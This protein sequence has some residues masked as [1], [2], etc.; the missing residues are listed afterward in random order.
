MGEPLQTWEMILIGVL[1]IVMLFL[2]VPGLKRVFAESQ[3]A[4]KDWPGF[5]IPIGCVIAV[6]T[7]LI[8]I[9]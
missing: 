4:E 2:F 9:T 8:L 7:L 6:V 5:L 3:K 1:G